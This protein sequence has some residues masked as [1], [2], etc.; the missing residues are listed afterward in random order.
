MH[1]FQTGDRVE[2]QGHPEFADG[3]VGTLTIPPDAIYQLCPPHEWDGCRRT[4]RCTTGRFVSYFV[5]F[6][7]PH[8]DG[9]GDGPYG[10]AEIEAEYLHLIRGAPG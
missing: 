1:H 6:D 10:G 3:I 7:E 5:R 9:S 2:L 4:F 8:D